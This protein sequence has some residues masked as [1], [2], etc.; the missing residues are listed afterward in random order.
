LRASILCRSSPPCLPRPLTNSPGA[1]CAEYLDNMSA[2]FW[3]LLLIP[4]YLLVH[5][6]EVHLRTDM[7]EDTV[8]A[9]L[10]LAAASRHWLLGS[11]QSFRGDDNS[12]YVQALSDFLPIVRRFK[13][14]DRVDVRLAIRV[15]GSSAARTA[16]STGATWAAVGAF[17]SAMRS[18]GLPLG[19]V[20]AS[21]EPDFD[22][23][24]FRM[25]A[26]CIGRI[27]AGKLILSLMTG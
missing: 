18:A 9:D 17:T 11:F 4:V 10:H 25:D 23:S 13:C 8:R 19:K 24:S 2:I 6:F 3:L 12:G 1:S 5:P 21:V 16:V 20:R 15:S 26:H 7:S 22:G 27:R 14:A